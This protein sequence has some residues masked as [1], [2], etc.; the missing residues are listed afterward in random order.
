MVNRVQPPWPVVFRIVVPDGPD[1]P[2]L[3]GLDDDRC[4]DDRYHHPQVWEQALDEPPVKRRSQIA[5]KDG[6][7]KVKGETWELGRSIR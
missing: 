2:Q 1:G 5:W 3:V 6:A 7:L 4:Y